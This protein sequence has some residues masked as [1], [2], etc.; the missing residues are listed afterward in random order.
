MKAHSL[1]PKNHLSKR[2]TRL[3]WGVL[4]P[5]V[6][7]LALVLVAFLIMRSIFP[8]EKLREIAIA[9][10]E[11]TTGLSISVEDAEISLVHWRIGVKVSG[12]EVA[13]GAGQQGSQIS[14]LA[15]IPQLGI[16]VSI[17][18]LLR[19]EIVVNELYVEKPRITLQL[20]GEPILRR[21]PGKP[22]AQTAIPMSF[23]LSR[24]VVSGADIE[25]RDVR[26][27]SVVEFRDLDASSSIG[28][29]KST[30][31]LSFEGKSSVKEVSVR[32]AQKLPIDI[33]PLNVKTSWKARV[34]LRDKLL[35]L[36]RVSVRVAEFP[37]EAAGRVS[38]A[39]EKPNLDV[40]VKIEKIGAGR[41]LALA[42]KVLPEKAK[43]V[44]IDGQIEAVARIRGKMPSPEVDVDRFE[45]SVGHSNVSCKA[46]LK[47]QEP[48]SVNFESNGN[49]RLDE[50][51]G[52]LPAGNGP[53]VT[54]G[55]ASFRIKGGGLI[56]ELKANPLSLQAEGHATISSVVVELP[57]P[58]PRVLLDRAEVTVAG[59]SVE[60]TGA[61]ARVGS[62]TFNATGRVRDWKERSVELDVSSPMLD[63]GEL[64]LPV[65]KQQKVS[66]SEATKS[67]V[68]KQGIPANGTAKLKVDKLKFGN[69]DAKDLNAKVVFGGDSVVVTDMTM[70]TLGG[71][72]SGKSRL[73]VPRE[74]AR[75]YKASFVA[76]NLQMRELLNSLTPVKE[77]MSGLSSFEISVEGTLPED[78][79]PLKSVAAKGQVATTQARA[80]ASPLVSAIASWVGLEKT[81]QYAI[82]DFSTSFFVQ[83]G[84]VIL[85]Q[86][87]LEEKNSTWNFAGSTGFDGSLD[88]KVNV[89]LSQE[90]S[91]RTGSLRGLEQLLKDDEGRVVVDL[92]VGG[93]VKKP[94]FKWDSTR[95]QQ[96]GQDLLT[97]KVRG[98]I[99]AQTK[100]GEALKQEVKTELENKTDSLKVE[101]ARKGAKLLEDLLK[102]GKK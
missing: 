47:T 55:T 88:Y 14:R 49:L 4:I 67:A 3:L 79:S 63:L 86:C 71:R 34:G 22:A 51:A 82:K 42:S 84:R 32:L 48:R 68:L 87:S 97:G 72:C 60:I 21:P 85:P 102:K 40:T 62:S 17:L 27:G 44:K 6:C 96:R 8:S 46:V 54:S 100:K 24:A 98:Q 11:E 89:T 61:T 52:V 83:E 5:A 99:E 59:R 81:D 93:T 57:R 15:T 50:L 26:S 9:R 25:L 7:V 45:V 36:E 39:G 28:A 53:R 1:N 23:S 80:I 69:F 74:G 56:K 66:K 92:I 20:G 90:Y 70:N 12:L 43:A 75:G 73:V 30:E 95:M 65:A 19:R 77:F 64:L 38:L 16:V 91:K 78:A 76:D 33:P 10:L 41:L 18:P 37:I 94:A 2:R 101:T 58:S 35:E 13:A 29:D 31:S